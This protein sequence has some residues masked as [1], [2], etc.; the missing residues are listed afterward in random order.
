MK[1]AQELVE[2]AKKYSEL[3]N[4]YLA[5]KYRAFIKYCKAAIAAIFNKN[6]KEIL[7][8]FSADLLDNDDITVKDYI[9][10]DFCMG[11]IHYDG[12]RFGSNITNDDLM[13]LNFVAHDAYYDPVLNPD[14]EK[15][16][17]IVGFFK[18]EYK[19]FLNIFSP[20][21]I[22]E[23]VVIKF[24]DELH[25]SCSS[26]FEKMGIHHISQSNYAFKLNDLE[27]RDINILIQKEFDK[28][29][30]YDEKALDEFK[31]DIEALK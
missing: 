30:E 29:R 31:K 13:I 10:I 15:D 28:Y 11:D 20:E 16:D 1:M 3:E 25:K 26:L 18:Q 27:I 8:Y 14:E 2:N 21:N 5:K 23:N 12:I 6:K 4:E 19:H 17:E 22:V 24:N 7:S 9:L